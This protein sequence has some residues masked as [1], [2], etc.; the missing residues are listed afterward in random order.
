MYKTQGQ[1]EA[2]IG[3][4]LTRF[5]KEYMGRGPLEI[6]VYLVDDMIIA[7]MKGLLTPAERQLI[8][9]AGTEQGRQL[10]KQMRRELLESA[11]PLLKAVVQGVTGCEVVGLHSD[12]STARGERVIIFILDK[13][14]AVTGKQ[15]D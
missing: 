6:R 9:G 14:P 7:R 13:A 1:L 8:S 10:V 11:Y 15:G 3:E 12:L 4:A 2:E 5:E